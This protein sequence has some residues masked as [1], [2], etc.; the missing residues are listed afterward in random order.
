MP[1][2]TEDQNHFSRTP[3]LGVGICGENTGW[4]FEQ[5]NLVTCED[6]KA[7]PEF[8]QALAVYQD[9]EILTPDSPTEQPQQA[10]VTIRDGNGTLTF[11]DSFQ[12]YMDIPPIRKAVLIARLE[13]LTEMLKKERPRIRGGRIDYG[14]GISGSY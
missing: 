4:F 6:C 2:L 9:P 10:S 13:T 5:P 8:Q 11:S 12:G 14:Q 3:S 1:K 7:T